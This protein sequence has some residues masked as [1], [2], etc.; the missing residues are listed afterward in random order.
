MLVEIRRVGL[1][2]IMR[3]KSH[4]VRMGVILYTIIDN[5]GG[6]GTNLCLAQ[7]TTMLRGEFNITLIQQVSGSSYC[8]ALDLGVWCSLH[9]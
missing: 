7:Y 3:L 8:T 4:W 6:H 5:S 9:A 1:G 2:V